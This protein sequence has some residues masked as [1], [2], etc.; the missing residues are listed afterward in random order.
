M[1]GTDRD[2]DAFDTQD[3]H[4]EIRGQGSQEPEQEIH[5]GSSA[6]DIDEEPR[7]SL[8]PQKPS[9][10]NKF[11]VFMGMAGLLVG[12]G[13]G[14]FSA[15]SFSKVSTLRA[16]IA[17]AFEDVDKNIAALG[18]SQTNT[19]VSINR[20]QTQTADN[21]VAI[22]QF[23]TARIADD[24]KSVRSA[25]DDVNSQLR[26][27]TMDSAQIIETLQAEIIGLK[28]ETEGLSAR[29]VEQLQ[30]QAAVAQQRRAAPAAAQTNRSTEPR[31]RTQDTLEGMNVVTV[32]SWG[33][34]SNVVLQDPKT[35]QYHTTAIGDR[36]LGWVYESA[37]MQ[38]GTVKFIKDRKVV[39]VPVKG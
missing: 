4:G 16:D 14:A 32:D 39:V 22:E 18:Q 24:V 20:L 27:S 28:A 29:Q 11:G 17:V 31:I 6:D 38:K 37:D 34:E 3:L 15:I 23:D 25:L 5:L 21:A 13:A 7:R 33:I 26:A 9:T 12:L 19:D 10:A 8:A 35:G 1:S 30:Q 2:N 36:V